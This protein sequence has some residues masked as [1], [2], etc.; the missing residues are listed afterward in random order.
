LENAKSIK[1]ARGFSLIE[2]C[3]LFGMIMIVS[4]FAIPSLSSAMRG[5]QLSGDARNIAS[6]LSYA[7]LSAA[8]QMRRFR[9][10]FTLGENRWEV[11]RFNS[12]ANE[13]ESD[14]EGKNLSTESGIGFK[15]TA[16]AA[17]TGYPSASS[18]TITFNS[19]GLPIDDA[20]I[21]AANSVVYISKDDSDFAVSVSLTGKVQVWKRNDDQWCSQ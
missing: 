15:T 2:I 19:R 20:G 17:L 5:L 8:S 13:F 12:A 9:V 1:S 10:S 4:A 7:K 14:L 3:I 18:S 11:Q 21:P 16:S 6:A